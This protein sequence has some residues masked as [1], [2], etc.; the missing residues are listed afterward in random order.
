MGFKDRIQAAKSREESLPIVLPNPEG[1]P[2]RKQLRYYRSLCRQVGIPYETA[3]AQQIKHYFKQGLLSDRI[4]ELELMREY[5]VLM[6]R[7]KGESTLLSMAET[8]LT[9]KFFKDL[10]EE[11]KLAQKCKELHEEVLKYGIHADLPEDNMQNGGENDNSRKE[12][13]LQTVIFLLI[14]IIL[15]FTVLYL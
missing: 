8:R 12:I 10:K 13:V 4:K 11:A 7:G 3:E 15:V 5:K 14:I 2:T 6:D 9:G 1:R